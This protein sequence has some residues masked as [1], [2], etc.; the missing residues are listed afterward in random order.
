MPSVGEAG[1]QHAFVA[2]DDGGA[3]VRRLDVGDEGEPGRSAA[4]RRAQREIALV[5]P[6]GDLHDLRRQVHVFVGDAP[7]QRDRPFHQ[8]GDLVE[9]AGIV[10]HGKLAVGGK[11]GDAVRDQAFALLGIDQHA[12]GAQFARPVGA[13][14]HGEGAG[15]VEAVALGQVAGGEAVAI[16]GAVAQ[17]ERHDGAVRAGR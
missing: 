4:V 6:H 1:A 16:V 12:M 5:D 13:A 10:H 8:A 7:E 14:G 17:V 11:A 3:A 9:Q 2:G 15:G